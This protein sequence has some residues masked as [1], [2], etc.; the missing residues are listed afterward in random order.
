[1][2]ATCF[3]KVMPTK[4]AGPRSQSNLINDRHT[5]LDLEQRRPFSSC[6]P[7]SSRRMDGQ[8]AT[9]CIEIQS[10]RTEKFESIILT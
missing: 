8:K 4:L 10:A 9:A 2:Y 3:A 5:L 7:T 6:S 1:M